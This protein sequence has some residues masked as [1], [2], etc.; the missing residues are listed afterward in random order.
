MTFVDR[1]FQ[2]IVRDVLTNLTQGVM[3]E[4][5][6]VDY[7]PTARPVVVPAIVLERRPVRRVSAVIGQVET[8]GSDDLI[9]VEFG[10]NDYALVPSADDPED[11]STIRF[12]PGGRRP[13]AGTDVVVNYYPRTT[14]PTVLSDVQ[15]GSVVRTLIEAISRELAVLY[16]QLNQA[17]DSGFVETAEGP[18]LGRVVALLG[19]RRYEAGRPV[20]SVRFG[21][22]PGAAGDIS[23]PAGTPVTD[24]EDRIRYETVETRTMFAGESTAEIRVRGATDTTPAVLERTLT[25]VQ[26]AIAGIDTV[27][28]ERPTTTSSTDESDVELR[29]RARAALLASNKGTVPALRDGLMQLPDVRAVNVQEFPNDVPG[30]IRLSISLNEPSVITLPPAVLDRIEELRPA[31]IRVIRDTASTTA[32]GVSV[33]LTLAGS[34]LPSADVQSIHRNVQLKLV[35]LVSK[36]GV[37]RPVRVGPLV[38]AIL[39]DERVVDASLRLGARGEPAGVAG[40]DYTPAPEFIASLAAEDVVFEADV[41][42][43]QAGPEVEVNVEVRATLPAVVVTGVDLASAREQIASRL[44]SYFST[45]APGTAVTMGSILTALQDDSK[46]GVDALRSLVTLQT[47]EQFV[48]VAQGG[49]A[50]TVRPGTTFSVIAVDVPSGGG[51]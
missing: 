37:G 30:E 46:Y 24:A 39:A 7:D 36:V 20:G 40:A 32:L 50:Y 3:G 2:D 34:H 6:R 38:A 8:P 15:V 44:R 4:V 43:E 33:S 27:T 17:Y 45:L 42:A 41:F 22:R 47:P 5:H 10:L 1:P 23:I 48:Q 51:V 16:T 35:N 19:L 18:S 14:D 21:R 12:L 28:N 29:A 9:R 26:R 13:A 25:V 31:G 11:V 49:E